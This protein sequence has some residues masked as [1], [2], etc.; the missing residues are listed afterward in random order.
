MGC[1][2][3]RNKES[4]AIVSKDAIL[5]AAA[6]NRLQRQPSVVLGERRPSQIDAKDCEILSDHDEEFFNEKQIP[7]SISGE[8]G[9]SLV[10][11]LKNDLIAATLDEHPEVVAE[12]AGMVEKNSL[13]EVI[14]EVQEVAFNKRH[15]IDGMKYKALVIKKEDFEKLGVDFLDGNDGAGISEE[16]V[17]L[18]EPLVWL[19]PDETDFYQVKLLETLFNGVLSR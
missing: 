7:R 5:G 6:P 14:Y 1:D 16:V 19:A 12:L 9:M 18:I 17:A 10:S 11:Q 8:I 15:F 4:S 2:F 3:C 13:D